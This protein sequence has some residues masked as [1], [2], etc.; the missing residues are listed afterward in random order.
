MPEQLKKDI[1]RTH[2]LFIWP[3]VCLCMF[4]FHLLVMLAQLNGQKMCGGEQKTVVF[5]ERCNE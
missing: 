3:F 5:H 1:Y 2:V 4:S